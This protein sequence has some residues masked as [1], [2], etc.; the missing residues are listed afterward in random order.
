MDSLT[1]PSQEQERPATL[2]VLQASYDPPGQQSRPKAL[3]CRYGSSRS[4][5]MF[6]MP[7][8]CATSATGCLP[9]RLPA[10]ERTTVGLGG[11]VAAGSPAVVSL[12]CRQRLGG[13]KGLGPQWQPV[14]SSAVEETPEVSNVRCKKTESPKQGRARALSPAG[15]GRHQSRPAQSI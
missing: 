15:A 14:Y 11:C 9:T 8:R 10:E 5:V 1:Y 6:S 3:G 4:T 7:C 13:F 12:P 2:C